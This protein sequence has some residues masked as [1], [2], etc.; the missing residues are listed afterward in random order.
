MSDTTDNSVGVSP[1]IQLATVE[2]AIRRCKKSAMAMAVEFRAA[3]KRLQ[4]RRD[5]L[6]AV[7]EAA[8]GQ[9]TK[10]E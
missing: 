9:R 8:A 4:A 6:L 5:E 7:V 10:G 3:E 1:A 2:A